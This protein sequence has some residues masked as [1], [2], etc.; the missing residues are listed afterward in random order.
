MTALT[1]LAG[2]ARA[3]FAM[4]VRRPV[5]WLAIPLLGAAVW[6][7]FAGLAARPEYPPELLV[8]EWAFYLTQLPPMVVAALLADRLVRDRRLGV[9]E[10]LG[11]VTAP[12]RARMAGKV[13]G[14]GAATLL[15]FLVT[16]LA[17]IAW[18]TVLKGPGE[19]LALAPLAFVAVALPP[20]VAVC[21]LSVLLPAFIPV[22]VYQVGF[23]LVWLWA[24]FFPPDRLAAP[25][26]TAFNPSGG[27]LSAAVFGVPGTWSSPTGPLAV[28]VNLA[29]LAALTAVPLL[30]VP[31]VLDARARRA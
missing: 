10:L 12:T 11:T 20:L 4:Q 6:Q 8:P 31:R 21:S 29:L 28:A 23:A 27:V 24:T 14:A 2:T 30:V 3:E 5:V 9:D 16:Y 7:A 1:T 22:P 13:L 19:V 15:V 17:G 26:E 18:L 25:T